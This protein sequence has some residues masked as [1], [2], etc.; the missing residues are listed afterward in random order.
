MAAKKPTT[1]N[2]KIGDKAES[3]RG[4]RIV[5]RPPATPRTETPVT[6]GRFPAR[7]TVGPVLCVVIEQVA[8]QIAGSGQPFV[9]EPGD[10]LDG[11]GYGAAFEIRRAWRDGDR[12]DI[13]RGASVPHG[14]LILPEA[15]PEQCLVKTRS[16]TAGALFAVGRVLYQVIA[17]ADGGLGAKIWG[18]V[19]PLVVALDPASPLALRCPVVATGEPI[20]LYVDRTDLLDERG[21]PA[22]FRFPTQ[23]MA[24]R[25]LS[26]DR[27]LVQPAS[28]SARVF[29]PMAYALADEMGHYR[30]YYYY[31][32]SQSRQSTGYTAPLADSGVLGA[33][34]NYR[35]GPTHW[36]FVL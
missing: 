10:L 36:R 34:Y 22:R 26:L 30:Y 31:F 4:D 11:L 18:D 24:L 17:A 12:L 33:H 35:E 14:V 9:V 32:K 20:P 8:V 29:G 7:T 2:P 25:A 15:A 27:E 1:P 28:L 23:N 3:A 5:H 6:K 13:S 21:G 16:L 19:E